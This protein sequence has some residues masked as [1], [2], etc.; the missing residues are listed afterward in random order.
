MRI[1]TGGGS[2]VDETNVLREGRTAGCAGK[3]SLLLGGKK[4]FVGALEGSNLRRE[5]RGKK[6]QDSFRSGAIPPG[7]AMTRE[8]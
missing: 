1:L 4:E 5:G 8:G 3:P 6:I 2:L 7:I